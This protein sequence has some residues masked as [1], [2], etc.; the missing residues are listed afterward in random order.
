MIKIVTFKDHGLL[1]G[2]EYESSF[3]LSNGK[4][5]ISK[6]TSPTIPLVRLAN[7]WL[8]LS[9]SGVGKKE[10]ISIF[11]EV[12]DGLYCDYCGTIVRPIDDMDFLSVLYKGNLT[13]C[14]RCKRHFGRSCD[15]MTFRDGVFSKWQGKVKEKR[16][17]EKKK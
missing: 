11:G 9:K 4:T 1:L 12:K 17:K 8:A 10:I 13:T 16:V 6:T 5:I 7:D 15:M 3:T 2:G 14:P